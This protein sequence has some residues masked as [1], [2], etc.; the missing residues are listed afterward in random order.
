VTDNADAV[1]AVIAT[2]GLLV[3]VE[4][5]QVVG[6]LIAGWDGWRGNFYRLAVRPEHQRKGIARRLVI[7]GEAVLQKR[8]CVRMAA[9]VIDDHAHA[10][11]FW[12][13]LGYERDNRVGRFTKTSTGPAE[14]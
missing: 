11:A 13:S 9:I 8:G 1:D 2:G 6:T 10:V 14:K 5:A 4:D 3:A 7:E 12:R